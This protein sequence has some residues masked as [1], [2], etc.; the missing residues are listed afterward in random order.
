MRSQPPRP[1]SS[2]V[3]KRSRSSLATLTIGWI[4]ATTPVTGSRGPVVTPTPEKKTPE[5]F[6][7]PASWTQSDA[8]WVH[9][10]ST[11]SWLVRNQGSYRVEFSKQTSKVLVFTKTRRVDW[12]IDDRGPS[13]QVEYFFDFKTL[14]RRVTVNGNTTDSKPVKLPPVAASAES[15]A[16][17]IDIGPDRIVIRDAQ[18]KELDQ[19]QRPNPAEP[20]GKF[21]F[22]GDVALV[23]K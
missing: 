9:K 7:D 13:N 17:R 21:G 2:L 16:I 3:R 15:Y 19:Y 23:V 8:W 11:T 22:K 1:A 6:Q 18:G 12:V 5:Y 10:G 14:V 20:L 4:L